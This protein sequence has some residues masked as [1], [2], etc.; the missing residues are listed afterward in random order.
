MK[1]LIFEEKGGNSTGCLPSI[2]LKDISQC[3]IQISPS[4]LEEGI[5]ESI[6]TLKFVG[7]ASWASMFQ[8]TVNFSKKNPGET[9][10][11]YEG[12]LWKTLEPPNGGQTGK[13]Y[14]GKHR[15]I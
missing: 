9:S 11:S 10:V 8:S 7:F 13:N 14:P 15:P 2:V 12:C 6:K 5:N 1:Y 3:I 4:A